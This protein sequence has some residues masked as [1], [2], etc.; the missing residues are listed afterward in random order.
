M[1][2]IFSLKKSVNNKNISNLIS[3]NF[4]NNFNT[5]NVTNMEYM[6]SECY[7]LTTTINILN[8]NTTYIEIFT[9]SLTDTNAK[10]TIGYTSANKSIVEAMKER[11]G[12]NQSKITLKQ[13]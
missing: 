9:N 13:I 2:R 6:F 8:A 12:S 1:R 3:I 4:N 10:V 11:A 5:S 7:K